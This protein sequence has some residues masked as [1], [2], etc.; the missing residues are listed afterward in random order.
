MP[1]RRGDR[2]TGNGKG[3]GKGKG[4]KGGEGKGKGG[5]V[6]L[7]ATSPGPQVVGSPSFSGCFICGS[8]QHYARN[9]PKNTAGNKAQTIAPAAA[10]TTLCGLCVETPN[11]FSPL[12]E[13]SEEGLSE[14][15]VSVRERS[16]E[17]LPSGLEAPRGPR[18]QA[19]KDPRSIC[20]DPTSS[21][22]ADVGKSRS[23]LRSTRR[24]NRVKSD[25]VNRLAST[26]SL[27]VV[28]TDWTGRSR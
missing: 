9:C 22:G 28:T 3:K 6:N 20:S 23:G 19:L 13:D 27:L 18:S 4:E 17:L 12:R 16:Y 11:P 2:K 10:L 1:S 25:K 7:N 15:E 21:L 26:G 8:K 24:W 14:Q 5:Q